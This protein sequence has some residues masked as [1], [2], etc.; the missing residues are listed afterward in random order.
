MLTFDK[1][2]ALVIAIIF[3]LS[4]LPWGLW[5]FRKDEE[6]GILE[7]KIIGYALGLVLVP[8][9]FLAENIVGIMYNP[10]LIY[11]NWAIVFLA[12]TTLVIKDKAFKFRFEFGEIFTQK[13]A[14]LLVLLA[15]M[16]ASFMV[17]FSVSGIP[18]MDLDPYFYLDGV[19]QVVYQGANNFNDGT[20]WYPLNVSSHIG[21]PIW[22][23]TLASWFSL[24]NGT[25]AYD[26]YTLIGVGSLFA[27]IIGAMT[28][29][30][31]YILFKNLYGR[32]TGLLAAGL[33]AFMPIMLVKFQGGDFQ[34][35]PYNIMALLF[36]FCAVA[37]ALSRPKE[38]ESYIFVSLACVATFLGSNLSLLVLFF[39]SAAIL[40]IGLAQFIAPSKEARERQEASIIIAGIIILCQLLLLAYDMK[41][42]M[43]FSQIIGSI[44]TTMLV[45]F[46]AAAAPCAMRLAANAYT[47]KKEL[48]VPKEKTFGAA[49]ALFEIANKDETVEEEKKFGL[50]TRVGIVCVLAIF[51]F[52]I[53][54][55]AAQTIPSIKSVV[56]TYILFGAYSEP[57][58][59]TIAEQAPGSEFY[60]NQL[61]VLAAPFEGV[62]ST[63][64]D[65]LIGIY[66]FGMGAANVL[67]VIPTAF[68]NA[69]YGIFISMM[70][71]MSGV[72]TFQKVDK[73]NS[74]LTFL[75]FFGVLALIVSWAY[76]AMKRRMWSTDALLLLP[77]IVPVLLVGFGKQK[78]VMYMAVAVLF[79]AAALWGSLE[80]LGKYLIR[81]YYAKDAKHEEREAKRKKAAGIAQWLAVLAV[82]VLVFFEFAG[83][84]AM[85][86]QIPGTT[87]GNSLFEAISPQY[88]YS[89]M[90]IFLNSF[91]PRIYDNPSV[92]VPKMKAYCLQDATNPLCKVVENWNG[93]NISE[94]VYYFNSVACTRSLWPYL[95]KSPP[96][97]VSIAMGYRCSFVA[98]YWQDSMNWISKNMPEQDRLISWWDYGHWINYFGERMAVL[99]NEHASTE[100]IGKT[101]T[102]YLHQDAKF[103]R[104][105]MKEYGSRYALVD[106]EII[107]DG[108]DKQQISLGGKYSALNYL[109]CA[110]QNKT[111]VEKWPGQ[112][113]CEAE[114]VWEQAIVPMNQTEQT[115]CTI[116]K[117]QGLGG[118]IGYGII[119]GTQNVEPRYCMTQ[120][121]ADGGTV[122]RAYKLNQT[123][124][125]GNLVLQRAEWKGYSDG[126]NIVLTAYYTKAQTWT[127]ANG[128]LVSGWEDRTTKFYDSNVYSA[129]FFDEIDGFDL[130]YSSPQ[131]RIFKMKDEYWNGGK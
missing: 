88:G 3:G 123:D 112:S 2:Y 117:E 18:I 57:L 100:M 127:D 38:I 101:A 75:T 92:V 40:A 30:F 50:Y 98:Y 47:R 59:R 126:R 19:R 8:A 82:F 15:I 58:Y 76:S 25:T 22:K 94:P 17:G 72:D 80:R 67:N 69:V 1:T 64:S 65:L 5:L 51:G 95:D 41:A 131:I 71:S 90:P 103:L 9:L 55:I 33:I 68:V 45:V 81:N 124:A 39:L 4:G 115:P 49:K 43:P 24:Y 106:I 83:A 86:L 79:L 10:V 35:E 99:R 116:S 60:T 114:H 91:T 104:D 11:V 118:V 89:A 63:N 28:A 56:D 128:N 111:T 46:L 113:E 102:A 70:N 74:M 54:A 6:I 129:F 42:G 125:S 110:W 29:F 61:G 109:G 107:G 7:K 130:V 48:T 119:S 53:F 97:D 21:Q 23:Y 26:P 32:R 62:Q 27:P 12:G 87:S 78:L 44:A 96:I 66:S 120:E 13:N 122:I 34:I 84:Y 37:Y 36:L 121:Y 108:T 77:F 31:A 85:A 105:T 20:A 52:I 16:F 73:G 93:K 14:L